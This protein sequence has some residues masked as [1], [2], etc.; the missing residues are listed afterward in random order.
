MPP[1]ADPEKEPFLESISK[2]VL[3]SQVKSV[4]DRFGGGGSARA[5]LRKQMKEMLNRAPISVSRS[6]GLM[7]DKSEQPTKANGDGKWRQLASDG[8][9]K[10]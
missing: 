6:N 5:A 8:K 4:R 10:P 7:A 9:G 3:Q 1:R 2:K